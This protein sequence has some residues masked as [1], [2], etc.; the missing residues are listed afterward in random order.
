V[1]PAVCGLLRPPDTGDAG[2]MP[3]ANYDEGELR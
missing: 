1:L 2:L 3:T